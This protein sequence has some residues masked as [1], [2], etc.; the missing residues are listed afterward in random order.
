VSYAEYCKGRRSLIAQQFYVCHNCRAVYGHPITYCS[1]CPGKCE[2]VKNITYGELLEKTGEDYG[3]GEDVCW[4]EPEFERNRKTSDEARKGI[5]IPCE[6]VFW[7]Y[8]Y[9][10]NTYLK[11]A[12][13]AL[14]RYPI[15]DPIPTFQDKYLEVVFLFDSWTEAVSK[16]KQIDRIGRYRLRD[17]NS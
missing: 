14:G 5:N 9:K 3:W 6:M 15:S 4:R 13:E 10:E 12:Q 2:W 7:F 8:D 1:N 17:A 11:Q 16:I